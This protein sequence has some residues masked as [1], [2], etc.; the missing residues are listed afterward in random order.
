MGAATGCAGAVGGRLEVDVQLRQLLGGH[1]L[2]PLARG[3]AVRAHFQS[4]RARHHS[5]R[6]GERQRA[7]LGAVHVER[8]A[9]DVCRHRQGAELLGHH[10]PRRFQS[11]SVLLHPL[12][13]AG[14]QG[15]LQVA[16]GL[17]VEPQRFRRQAHLPERARRGAQLVRL[18]EAGQG[19][20]FLALAPQRHAL[21]DERVGLRFGADLRL[22][23]CAHAP[24]HSSASA[25]HRAVVRT[26]FSS[27]SVSTRVWPELSSA[28]R[29]C[30]RF[31]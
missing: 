11:G 9:G 13:R 20:T 17:H 30:R 16:F 15:A 29:S 19:L 31:R 27:V 28:A 25:R 21:A 23:S 10:V 14:G 26:P 4:N 7:R 2:C 6:A 22:V 8:G 12:V 18:F 1:H 24:G 5:E 3:V